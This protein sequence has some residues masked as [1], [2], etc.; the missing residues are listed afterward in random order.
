MAE[1]G[2]GTGPSEHAI[3][4]AKEKTLSTKRR[5]KRQEDNILQTLLQLP[6]PGGAAVCSLVRD[7]H[8]WLDEGGATSGPG[9]PPHASAIDWST[10]PLACDPLQLLDNKQNTTRRYGMDMQAQIAAMVL[11]RS[12]E[13]GSSAAAAA[14]HEA[15]GGAG[16]HVPP[17]AGKA[18]R[19]WQKRWQV[20]RMLAAAW[21]GALGE[22]CIHHTVCACM[23][24]CMPHALPCRSVPGG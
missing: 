6:H 1:A 23:C 13:D 8:C 5:H 14:A 19:G 10:C 11:E 24:T 16:Q 4:A 2:A 9:S 20:R 18:S 7:I 3:T 22:G 15:A 21:G 17:A 12:H